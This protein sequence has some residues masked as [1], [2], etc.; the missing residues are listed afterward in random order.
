[1]AELVAQQLL[2]A[3]EAIVGRLTIEEM[4]ETVASKLGQKLIITTRPASIRGTYD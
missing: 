3:A 4:T 1:M 2:R